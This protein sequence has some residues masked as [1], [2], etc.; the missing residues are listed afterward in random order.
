[1]YPL[2]QIECPDL[3]WTFDL[4]EKKAFY[5]HQLFIRFEGTLIGKKI[6]RIIRIFVQ[7]RFHELF[8]LTYIDILKNIKKMPIKVRM[9]PQN[10]FQ[11]IFGTYFR[12]IEI[13]FSSMN[14]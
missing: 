11:P 2:S 3:T 13:Y 7:L 9:L 8:M 5:S 12:Y 10:S 14:Y 4:A 6:W 1:M